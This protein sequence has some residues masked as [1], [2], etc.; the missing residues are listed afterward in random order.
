MHHGT[1]C[2]GHTW[3]IARRRTYSG[4]GTIIVDSGGGRQQQTTYK[5]TKTTEM[6]QSVAYAKVFG[7]SDREVNELLWASDQ[8]LSFTRVSCLAPDSA[9]TSF[10]TNSGGIYGRSYRYANF[11]YNT[12]QNQGQGTLGLTCTPSED[13][14]ETLKIM[15]DQQ[16]DTYTLGPYT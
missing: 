15:V 7:A 1:Y 10:S 5:L 12:L 13:D 9:R 11:I 16:A 2:G 14:D 3:T 4:S 8:W 6:A